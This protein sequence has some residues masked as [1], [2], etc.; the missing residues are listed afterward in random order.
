MPQ[1]RPTDVLAEKWVR[2]ASNAV[3]AWQKGAIEKGPSRY[4]QGVS[5]AKDKWAR[6]WEPYRQV[7]LRTQLP[8]RGPKGSRQNFERVVAVGM[9]LHEEARRRKS[10]GGE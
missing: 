2:N 4:A 5:V 8:E 6:E 3:Y 10:R 9:A 7:L 1:V